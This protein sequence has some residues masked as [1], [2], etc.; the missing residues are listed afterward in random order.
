MEMS[1]TSLPALIPTVTTW[2]AMAVPSR[3]DETLRTFD[4]SFGLFPQSLSLVLGELLRA[5]D[6][7]R[8]ALDDRA[9]ALDDCCDFCSFHLPMSSCV[10]W[11]VASSSKAQAQLK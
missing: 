3:G 11:R 7:A 10:S 5:V 9:D 8:Q 2:H 4:E 1:G 6:H